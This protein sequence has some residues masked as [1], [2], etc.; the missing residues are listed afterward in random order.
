[1]ETIATSLPVERIRE[2]ACQTPS[3]CVASLDP[4]LR[5]L[6]HARTLG[7]LVL[8]NWISIQSICLGQLTPHSELHLSQYFFPHPTGQKSVA[9]RTSEA[10]KKAGFLIRISQGAVCGESPKCPLIMEIARPHPELWS[11]GLCLGTYLK[12]AFRWFLH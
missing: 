3:G 1:M 5:Q 8:L 4:D 7:Y 10:W 6:S 2:F 11:R 12:L 9:P